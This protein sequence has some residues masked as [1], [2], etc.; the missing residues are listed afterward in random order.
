MDPN[1]LSSNG[2]TRSRESL[3]QQLGAEGCHVGLAGGSGE[4]SRPFDT[5]PVDVLVLD[6]NPPGSE[7]WDVFGVIDSLNPSF[8]IVI[9]V[10]SRGNPNWRRWP[11]S[12]ALTE[13][14]FN[15]PLLLRTIKR[16][17]CLHPIRVCFLR[18][19]VSVE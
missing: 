7:G 14:S 4:D 17:I 10:S 5:G 3:R 18:E 13:K 8:P 6:L 2:D 12:G 1:I 16:S 15:V 19:Q 9:V 11:A